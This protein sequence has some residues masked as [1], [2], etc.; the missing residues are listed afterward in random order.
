MT[1]LQL[2][3]KI[4][5]HAPELTETEIRAGLNEISD[6]YCEETKVLEDQWAFTTNAGQM[7]YD[8]DERCVGVYEVNLAGEVCDE[9]GDVNQILLGR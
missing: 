3:E 4:K 6:L 1:Q 2:I 7:Y 8:L 9:I 5:R